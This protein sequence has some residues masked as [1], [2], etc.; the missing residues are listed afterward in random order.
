M[1]IPH[2]YPRG[3]AYRIDF[4]S[5]L[6]SMA[7]AHI[8]IG[9]PFF[10]AT[11]YLFADIIKALFL[12]NIVK[13]RHHGG[14]QYI[15]NFVKALVFT[16]GLSVAFLYPVLLG[17]PEA[18]YLSLFVVSMVVRDYLS[19]SSFELQRPFEKSIDRSRTAFLC[20]VQGCFDG[21]CI[22]LLCGRVEAPVL[23][24]LIAA[25]VVTGVVHLLFP[26]WNIPSDVK[27]IENKYEALASYRLF[28]DMHLYSTIALN[29]GV[30]VFFF[31]A[32]SPSASVFVPEVYVGLALWLSMIYLVLFI[33]SKLIKRRWNGLALAEFLIGCITWCV[34]VVFLYR[35]ESIVS[36][37]M[38]TLVWGVGLALI[39]ESI[40]KFHNDFEAVG[41]IA[42]GTYDK[43]SLDISNIIASTT[44]S[45]IS[46]TVMLA[47]M[48]FWTF[49]LPLLPEGEGISDG[50]LW[51]LHM[52]VLFM[53]PA[54]IFAFRQPLDYRNREKLMRFI[55]SRSKTDRMRKNLQGLFVSKY[56]MRF[57][58][59]I[60]CTLARPV[61]RLKVSGREHLDKEDSPSVFVCNHGFIYGPISAVIY[62]P[63]YFRPWIHNVMLVRESAYKEMSKS[64][65][66]LTRIFGKAIGGKMI[67]WLSKAVCWVLNSCNPI[68]VV[69]GASRDVLS[70]FQMSLDALQDGDNILIFP[71]KPR[72]LIKATPGEEYKA[73]TVRTFYTGFAHIGKLYYEQTGKSL[74][75]YPLF[76]DREKRAFRIGEPVRYNAA[77]D[78]HESKRVLAEELQCKM[79]ELMSEK[80]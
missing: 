20:L 72:N 56:R 28:E 30:M 77:L 33:S 24:V 54:L 59:K 21:L 38:W 67:W 58:V 64:L 50:G 42:D 11:V 41:S 16:G 25:V 66:V 70:T 34:G 49:V 9:N 74:L 57:G 7:A 5:L 79:E 62:L 2:T 75:F 61:L 15:S 37:M 13:F 18:N 6:L 51:V 45:I 32:L 1:D 26:D 3:S 4:F 19:T 36:W 14:G 55:E 12:C 52:P 10:G 35:V 39:S 68:P 63:T 60:L 48:A 53:I 46:S 47:L 78:S 23:Y 17:Q 22:Y 27:I 71:E 43:A 44:A 31:F 80:S 29:L 65:R 73:D 69:R 8:V 40:K 76:S